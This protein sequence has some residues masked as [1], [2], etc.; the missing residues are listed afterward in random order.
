M[1]DAPKTPESLTS[2]QREELL[3]RSWMATDGLWFYQTATQRGIDGANEANIEVVREFGRQ[4]MV[5]LMR[6]LGVE[7]VETVEQY[8]RLFQTAVDLYLGSLFAARETFEDGVQH[9]AVSTCFAHKG[10]QR[11]GIDKIY[12][13]G[14]GERLTGWLQAM[15]LPAEIDPGVGL[16]QMAH[17]GACSYRLKL[18][19][20]HES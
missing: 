11:A 12:H 13:C 20:P 2:E 15:G 19:L 1:T 9:L 7:K 17:T 6:G 10:V 3:R 4:E 8:R 14:P 16:C 5:R 18:S